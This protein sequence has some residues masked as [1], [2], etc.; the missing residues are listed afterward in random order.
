MILYSVASSPV[1]STFRYFKGTHHAGAKVEKP[2]VRPP[3]GRLRLQSE[4]EAWVYVAF[5]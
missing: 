3:A 5:P 2:K 4:G 1:K